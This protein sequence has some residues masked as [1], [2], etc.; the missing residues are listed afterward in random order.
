MF[1]GM[2]MFCLLA[3]VAIPSP[4]ACTPSTLSRP[5]R[6]AGRGPWGSAPPVGAVA[7]GCKADLSLVRLDTMAF[8]PFN[9][10][11]RQ[12]AFSETGAGVDTVMV[13]GRVVVR[14]GRMT[15]VDE[16]AVRAEVEDIMP[17]FRR[18]FEGLRRTSAEA[19]PALIEALRRLE[20]VDVGL[21]RHLARR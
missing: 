14:G 17:A 15:T 13:G 1:Q 12:L 19:A 10:A 11:A 3:G 9:S 18:D 2:K 4:P 16:A 8:T 5:R 21:D 20:A 6:A 7:P